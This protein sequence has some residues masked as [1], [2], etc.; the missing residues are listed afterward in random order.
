M[1]LFTPGKLILILILAFVIFGPKKLP[2]LG[3]SAGKALFEFKTALRN[4]DQN[5]EEAPDSVTR[6]NADN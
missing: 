6:K 2:E 3:S 4:L 1:E 5:N